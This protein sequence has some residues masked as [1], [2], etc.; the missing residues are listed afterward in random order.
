MWGYLLLRFGFEIVRFICK[1]VIYG[2]KETLVVIVA[3]FKINQS[4]IFEPNVG[5][6]VVSDL[7][8]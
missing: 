7:V 3:K 4:V 2:F 6:N 1:T 8:I 5:R